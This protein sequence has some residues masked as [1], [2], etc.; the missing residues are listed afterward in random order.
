MI[1]DLPKPIGNFIFEQTD[2]TPIM[3]LD[4]AYYHYADVCKLLNRL[5]QTYDKQTSNS[6]EE[7]PQHE[8]G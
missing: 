6:N 1:E 4:G 3:G 2:I 5:K 7:G 8:E